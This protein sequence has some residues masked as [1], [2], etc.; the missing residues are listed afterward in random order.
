ME[1]LPYRGDHLPYTSMH[2]HI[3]CRDLLKICC[4]FICAAFSF[5]CGLLIMHASSLMVRQNKIILQLTLMIELF[6][7]TSLKTLMMLWKS[8]T[9]KKSHYPRVK[10]TGGTTYA[11]LPCRPLSFPSREPG[12][13]SSPSVHL[14]FSLS[15]S[16]SVSRS[17]HTPHAQARASRGGGNRLQQQ[18][19][20]APR[21]GARKEGSTERRRDGRRHPKLALL[22]LLLFLH[23]LQRAFA[24]LHA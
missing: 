13:S 23:Q 10:K 15:E 12:G 4:Q 8:C 9:Q 16:M 24:G 7:L 18:C 14:S 21:K 2:L 11:C 3:V 5:A 17:A 20:A 1:V 22:L 6:R 19:Q